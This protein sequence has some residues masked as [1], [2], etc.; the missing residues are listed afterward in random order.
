MG[1]EVVGEGEGEGM[2]ADQDT[3]PFK[4]EGVHGKGSDH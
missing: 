2:G 3:H 1:M 4:N